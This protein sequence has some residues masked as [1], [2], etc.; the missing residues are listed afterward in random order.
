MGRA[1][2][3]GRKENKKPFI[4]H[5]KDRNERHI[6]VKVSL[7]TKVG[8]MKRRIAA[9]E[10]TMRADRI[11]IAVGPKIFLDDD[12]KTLADCELNKDSVFVLFTLEK[13]TV[14]TLERSFTLL[15]TTNQ[16]IRH[17][18]MAIFLTFQN[19]PYF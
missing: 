5:V 10:P 11:E 17:T 3:K 18:K 2:G 16:Q 8:E 6:S 15:V 19:T 1:K 7:E 13:L 14:Q 12:E 4:A 9:A